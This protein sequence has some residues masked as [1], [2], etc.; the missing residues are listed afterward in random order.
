MTVTPRDRDSGAISVVGDIGFFNSN[1]HNV[2]NAVGLMIRDGE[3]RFG[4]FGPG[5]DKGFRPVEWVRDETYF[6]EFEYDGPAE[7]IRWSAYCGAS[8][9][10]EHLGTFE[11][12][13]Q[14]V[15]VNELGVG[16]HDGVL[17]DPTPSFDAFLRV[18]IDDFSLMAPDPC[19]ADLVPDGTLNFS[20]VLLF[21]GAFQ[22]MLPVADLAPP[23]GVIDFSDI[24]AYLQAFGAGCP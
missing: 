20:D 6:L 2:D 3:S 9:S 8:A 17:F 11:Q 13:V 4:A 15:V 18:E 21:L 16:S 7:V 10:G 5:V 23:Y 14:P 24:V 12:S 19:V 22:S 1:N